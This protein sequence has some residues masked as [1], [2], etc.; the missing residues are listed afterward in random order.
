MNSTNS[1]KEKIARLCAAAMFTALICVATMVIQIPVPLGGYVNF[2]DSFIITC[3]W[4]LGPIYGFAAGGI[5]SALADIFS[6]WAAYAPATFIIK[7]LIGCVSAL[8]AHYIISRRENLRPVA[9]LAGAAVAEMIMASGYY[10]YDSVFMGLGF[11]AAVASLLPN[12]TQAIAGIIF[13][14]IIAEVLRKTKIS[15]NI[16]SYA[17]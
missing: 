7:G 4:V 14:F 16:G 8:V 13:S 17:M 2:G 3:G 6:G 1:N 5:G 12:L 10:L 11:E 9:H 15:D